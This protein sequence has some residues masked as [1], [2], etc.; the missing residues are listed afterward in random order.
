MSLFEQRHDAFIG[1]VDFYRALFPNDVLEKEIRAELLAADKARLSDALINPDDKALVRDIRK[2][3]GPRHRLPALPPE[4][5]EW[6]LQRDMRRVA[7]LLVA[8]WIETMASACARPADFVRLDQ[9]LLPPY[10]PDDGAL[11]EGNWRRGIVSRP[12]CYLLR[13]E[14]AGRAFDSFIAAVRAKLD[15]KGELSLFAFPKT[16]IKKS[17]SG[18]LILLG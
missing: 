18:Y 7:S 12:S 17:S 3:I 2:A 6:L 13:R 11:D 4:E 16:T 9:S 10:L 14:S 5:T 8:S 1:A 15:E